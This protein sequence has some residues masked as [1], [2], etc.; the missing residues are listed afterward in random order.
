MQ[1]LIVSSEFKSLHTRR[2]R[3]LAALAWVW[4]MS[5]AQDHVA[6]P[7]AGVS[8]FATWIESRVACRFGDGW[9]RREDVQPDVVSRTSLV[10]TNGHAPSDREVPA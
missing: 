10:L 2:L 1:G 3:E 5:F 8:A 9:S 4:T 7:N 6:T